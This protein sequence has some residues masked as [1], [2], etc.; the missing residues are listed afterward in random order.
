MK[1]YLY[2]SAAL[3]MVAVACTNDPVAEGGLTPSGSDDT[4]NSGLTTVQLASFA[5]RAE[6]VSYE[7]SRAEITPAALEL[8]ATIDNPATEEGFNFTKEENGRDLSATCVFYDEAADKFYVT[9]HMQGNNYNTSLETDTAGAIQSFSVVENEEGEATVVLDKGFRAAAP[10][11]EDFDFNHIYFDQTSNRILAVGHNVK[12]GNRKNTNAIVGLFDPVKG[13]YSYKTVKTAEKD[14]DEETGKSL[15][16]KDAGDVNCIIRPNDR[17]YNYG[18]PL[19]AVATRKGM[20]LLSADEKTMFEPLLTPEGLNYFV[21]T[22]GSA[23]YVAHTGSSSYIGL[24]YLTSGPKGAEVAADD[25]SEAKIAR[26]SINTAS[27]LYNGD[28]LN[29]GWLQT[30]YAPFTHLDPMNF[31]ATNDWVYNLPEGKT[32]TPIDGKNTLA[33]YGSDG[34]ERYVAL[35]KGGMYYNSLDAGEGVK[36]FGD[37]PVNCVVVDT[38]LNENAHAGCYIYVANGSKLTIL[39]NFTLADVA[40][41]NDDVRDDDGNVLPSSANYVTVRR[42]GTNEDAVRYIAVAFGQ[43]GVKVFKFTP[44]TTAPAVPAE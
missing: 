37:R 3:A 12:N 5:G 43:A 26:F 2:L 19:Y 33:M 41:Y 25:E 36:K 18:W 39:N 42:T 17:P 4:T 7:K 6:R 30:W 14:Y 1:K 20:A 24:L 21:A 15:G 28:Y 23:K 31:E 34:Q 35:G 27:G 38:P 13:L 9:Y 32:I 44:E 11:V 29:W 40:S 8:V 10:E 22:P 16:Y